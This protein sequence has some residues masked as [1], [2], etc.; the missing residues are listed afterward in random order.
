MFTKEINRDI[1]FIYKFHFMEHCFFPQ[2]SFTLLRISIVCL[3]KLFSFCTSLRY[4][5]TLLATVFVIPTIRWTGKSIKVQEI[6][7]IRFLHKVKKHFY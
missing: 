2:Q 6:M 5:N 3:V 1:I 7:I 4:I